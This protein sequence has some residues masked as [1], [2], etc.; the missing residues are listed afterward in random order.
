MRN[1]C[2]TN[3]TKLKARHMKNSKLLLLSI[4]AG[5]FFNFVASSSLTPEKSIAIA[6]D[7]TSGG[8]SPVV[9][10]EAIMEKQ[11]EE[12]E[13]E[14]RRDSEFFS[15]IK[16][17]DYKILEHFQLHEFDDIDAA[18]DVDEMRERN[19]TLALLALSITKI[20]VSKWLALRLGSHLG[21]IL[22]TDYRS[23]VKI[24]FED[25][26]DSPD[27]PYFI[28]GLRNFYIAKN[29]EKNWIPSMNPGLF[30]SPELHNVFAVSIIYLARN[31]PEQMKFLKMEFARYFFH[32]VKRKDLSLM[33]KIYETLLDIATDGDILDVLKE[34]RDLRGDSY[35]DDTGIKVV[36]DLGL[37]WMEENY[38]KKAVS[39]LFVNLFDVNDLDEYLDEYR[40]K[41]ARI[42]DAIKE[43]METDFYDPKKQ[44][45]YY[46]ESYDYF[47]Q[48]L[49]EMERGIKQL[50]SL[51][52][53]KQAIQE[54]DTLLLHKL[55]QEVPGIES[56]T[57]CYI[58]EDL[59]KFNAKE[60][61]KKLQKKD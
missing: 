20:R 27:F 53:A 12:F 42:L 3:F 24:I 16:Y 14:I 11:R 37:K 59:E 23:F 43:S 36:V 55:T 6:K 52:E 33:S 29:Q 15:P 49:E 41:R 38:R 47:G 58:D 25:L 2:Q 60:H 54:D 57:H 30:E 7:T 32:G 5:L 18:T 61:L 35:S 13:H 17:T 56:I 19:K 28:E 51:K 10:D 39:K 4:L 44:K 40:K 45:F 50:E 9:L 8:S 48:K 1:P 22:E 31:K 21:S 26:L 46:S 34:M